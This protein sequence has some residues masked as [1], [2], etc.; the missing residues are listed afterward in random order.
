MSRTRIIVS[1]ISA[2]EGGKEPR[3]GNVLLENGSAVNINDIPLITFLRCIEKEIKVQVSNEQERMA[4]LARL[5]EIAQE[6]AFAP[7]LTIPVG[8]ILSRLF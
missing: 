3:S 5:Q 4:L 7:I 8:Q 6:P 2:D 1:R